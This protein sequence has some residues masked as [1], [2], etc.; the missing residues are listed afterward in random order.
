MYRE[1]YGFTQ[2]P[3]QLTADPACFFETP[4]HRQALINLGHGLARGEGF[5][6]LTGEIGAGKT[7]LLAQL[8]ATINREQVITAQLA[9]DHLVRRCS[10]DGQ[11]NCGQTIPAV[12]GAFGVVIDPIFGRAGNTASPFML[13]AFLCFLRDEVRAGRRC[14]LIVEEAQALSIAALEALRLMS[15]F[16]SGD[17]PLLQILLIG[18]PELHARLQCHPELERLRQRVVAAHDL[19]PLAADEVEPYIHHR[20]TTAGWTGNPGFAP[21]IFAEIHAASSGLP[22]RINQIADRLLLLAAARQAT[23]VDG[24]MLAQVLAEW[25]GHGPDRHEKY[26]LAGRD[27]KTRLEVALARSEGQIAELRRAVFELA[28]TGDCHAAAAR[29]RQPDAALEERIASLESR[30]IEQDRTIRHTLTMLIEWIEQDEPYS[31]AA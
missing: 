23:H 8:M 14:L 29:P 5:V 27:L 11:L 2:L 24:P 9:G 17:L 15:D 19:D 28:E 6:V 22:R 7:T 10:A 12:A 26:V 16:Q 13:D 18:Q 4:G 30:V 21:Q 25:T 20:L 31:V 3:F 1:F